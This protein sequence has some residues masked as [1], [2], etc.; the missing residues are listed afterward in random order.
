[1][2][3]RLNEKRWDETSD[4]AEN[5]VVTDEQWLLNNEQ[6]PV[7]DGWLLNNEQWPLDGGQ[8]SILSWFI[9]E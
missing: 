3:Q 9:E 2:S 5:S 8:D 1:M 6:W 4:E 7:S